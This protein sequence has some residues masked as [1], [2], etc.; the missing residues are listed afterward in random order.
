MTRAF[1]RRAQRTLFVHDA[2][3]LKFHIVTHTN[4]DGYLMGLIAGLLVDEIRR[5]Q[6]SLM[7]LKV[8]KEFM[9]NCEINLESI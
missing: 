3:F 7:K 2:M 9:I 6:T 8:N 5:R 1:V 4:A